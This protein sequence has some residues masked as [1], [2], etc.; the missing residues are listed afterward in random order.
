[1]A[2]VAN[3]GGP[4]AAVLSDPQCASVM[5]MLAHFG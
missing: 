4:D 2:A 5:A 3:G 1:M